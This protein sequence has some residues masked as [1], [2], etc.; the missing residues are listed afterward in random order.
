MSFDEAYINLSELDKE[1]P[2]DEIGGGEL[3]RCPPDFNETSSTCDLYGVG[4]SYYVGCCFDLTTLIRGVV[5]GNRL[6]RTPCTGANKQC[7]AEGVITVDGVD[8]YS[9]QC[10]F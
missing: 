7:M 1:F 4:S 3:I 8:H 5:G 10:P 9:H 2:F 6:E